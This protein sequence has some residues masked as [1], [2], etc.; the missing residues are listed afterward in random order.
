MD[1]CLKCLIVL[2]V[3][4]NL[5]FKSMLALFAIHCLSRLPTLLFS[6]L[7]FSPNSM[8]LYYQ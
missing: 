7:F 6:L 2:K 3:Y 8:R 4:V 5:N 1:D